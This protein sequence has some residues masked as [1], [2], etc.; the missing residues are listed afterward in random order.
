MQ[1]EDAAQVQML[2]QEVFNQKMSQELWQ[3][4]YNH[5]L[6]KATVVFQDGKLIAHYGGMG[7]KVSW[8]GNE[9]Q[10]VQITDVMVARG[11]RHAV[12]SGSPF[13]LAFTEFARLFLGYN[14]I[15]PLAFGFPNKRVMRLAQ[16]LGFYAPVGEMTEVSWPANKSIGSALAR[17]RTLDTENLAS[18]GPQVNALWERMQSSLHDKIVGV[19]NAAYIQRRYLEHPDRKYQVVLCQPLPG[20]Q[21]LG[22]LVLR[23]DSDKSFLMDVIADVQDIPALLKIAGHIVHKHGSREFYTWCSSSFSAIFITTG[24]STSEL[25]ITVP[26]NIWTPGPEPAA[27]QDLWWLMPGDTD[28][29]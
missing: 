14:K 18:Y 9:T 5:E 21:P 7:R 22:V 6:A 28:F 26:A 25:P 15:F 17:K 10:A 29:Q 27:L 19:K 24:C 11:S 13:Y 1:P 8:K 16:L 4:K 20:M 12:R 23:H 2:F 3:W